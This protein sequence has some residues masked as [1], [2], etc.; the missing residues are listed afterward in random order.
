MTRTKHIRGTPGFTLVEMVFS[1]LILG[2]IF[3]ALTAVFILFQRSSSATTSYAEAQQNA[4]IAVDFISD[5]LRQAG[6]QTDYF[7]GQ[8]AI[9]HAGPYQI[10]I[11][12]DIDNGQTIDGLSPL[13]AVNPTYSP[14]TIPAAG[15]VL[16]TP[17][18]YESNAETV[19]LTIDS[20]DDG[21]VDSSDRGD[22][23]EES[24]VNVNLFM[25]RRVIYGYDG[26]GQNEVRP[27]N[28]ALVRGPNLAT[29]MTTPDPLFQ[30][31]YDNDDDPATADILW[32][33]ANGNG[34]IDA[35]EAG[36][37]APVSSANLPRIRKVRTTAIAESNRFDKRYEANDG[38]L[39][40]SMNSE[41]F[42]RNATRTSSNV[43]GRVY[44]DANSN[45]QLDDGETGLNNVEI[46]VLGTSRET[47]T[48]AFGNFYLSLPPSDYSIQETD[49]A[50]YISTTSNLVSVSLSAGQTQVLYFGDRASVPIGVIQGTVFD[51]LDQNGSQSVDEPGIPGVLISL[52]NGTEAFSNTNGYYSFIAQQGIYTV[53]ETDPTGY[54][55]TTPNSAPARIDNEGDTV[56]VNFGDCAGLISG[57]LQGYVFDDA[58]NNGIFESGEDGLGSVTVRVSTGDSTVTNDQGYFRFNLSPGV[59]SLTETDPL[60]YTS[61]TP[62]TCLDIPITVDT[63]VTRIFGDKLE[64]STNFVEI[65]ISN[66][67]RVLSVS[68]ADLKEDSYGDNDIILGTA[69]VPGIGNLL[70]FFN[71]WTKIT[72]P[73]TK[74]FMP[75]PDY[76]RNAGKNI[77]AS[78]TGDLNG[79]NVPDVFTGL[80]SVTTPNIQAWL[81][82]S[83]GLLGNSPFATYFSSGSSVIM[84]SKLVRLDGDSNLDLIVGLKSSLG[85][86]SGGFQIFMGVGTGAFTSYQYVTT[87]G[88]DDDISLGEIW[89]IES[90]DFDGDGDQDIVI[91]SHTNTYL[92]YL[93]VYLNDGSGTFAWHSRYSVPYAV[94][95]IK[96]VDMME[97]DAG[98]VDIVAAV[99]SGALTGQVMLWLNDSC[100]FGQAD[101]TGYSFGHDETPHLPSDYVDAQG[102][103][104]CLAILNFN[105]DGFPD[106]AFGTRATLLY[107]GNLY[108]LPS[109]GLLPNNGEKINAALMGEIITMA[110]TDLNKDNSIDIV[111]GTRNS[112]TEGKLIAYFTGTL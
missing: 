45:G 15:T 79:N 35:A 41:V 77:N 107:Q 20:S 62:N 78:N 47:F 81:T 3:I 84:D 59:Y 93:D 33:D 7:R 67:D 9:A 71:K 110:V 96:A 64:V 48:D 2:I 99:S 103:A 36:S 89:A 13:I 69:L 19:V 8:P 88:A 32:G 100:L 29:A 58:N 108:V 22:D 6:S 23:P 56:T 27:S 1:V 65:H 17:L 90:A 34:A 101:T 87:A 61:T 102:A 37:V 5:I 55:S 52:D 30:Y 74:L 85:T 44:H 50:G 98:D 112:A 46:T 42:V 31:W 54:S 18:V 53:I 24:G 11:N 72:T 14:N 10:V 73:L 91:G 75:N 97:D 80:E 4:R 82:A 39:A 25:L 26:A 92:G 83:G 105:N 106:I 104:L 94:N 51:D 43:Y 86:F 60:G 63:T 16:Y 68:I 49:P 66:T 76:R 95:D 111:L 57:T 28:L 21:V 12:A 70:V 38:F 109:Y 40:V